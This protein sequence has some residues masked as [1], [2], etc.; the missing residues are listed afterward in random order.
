MTYNLTDETIKIGELSLDKGQF[1]IPKQV[2]IL[3]ARSNYH[4]KE[5]NGENVKTDELAK[6]VCTVQDSEKVK[7]LREMGMNVEELKSITLEFQDNLE[8]I[9]QLAANDGLIEKHIELINPQ[10]KLQW[11]TSRK[12]WGGVKL[13]A[14]DLKIIG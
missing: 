4:Y 2:I 13:V 9:S 14:Q 11:N 7:I 5:V 6:L 12:N 10:V 1:T 8:K 3:N